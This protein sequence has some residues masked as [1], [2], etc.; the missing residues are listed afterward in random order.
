MTLT[1]TAI[2]KYPGVYENAIRARPDFTH[3]SP[4]VFDRAYRASDMD[5]SGLLYVLAA[6]FAVLGLAGVV[7]P[8]LPGL[9]LLFGAMLL[10]AWA[11]GFERIGMW[12]LIVLGLL[13]AVSFVVDFWA[14]AVGAKRVGASRLALVGTL[15]GTVVGLFFGLP[16][17]FAGPFIGAVIGELV[18]RRDLRPGG[19]G[20][21][22][23]VGIGTWVG[24]A[25]GVALKLALA[26]L[27][28]AVFAFAWWW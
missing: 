24:I 5:L 4:R 13:T 10:A 15:I 6:L 27:M 26:V 14:T 16:G 9:P 19:L 23:R 18:S 28:L 1:N 2:A 8:A 21:A 11:N 25:L 7:L 22:T 20:R 3:P 17:L 12:S